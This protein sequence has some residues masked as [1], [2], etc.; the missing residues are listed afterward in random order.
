MSVSVSQRRRHEF[1]LSYPRGKFTIEI[2]R[3][4]R[5]GRDLFSRPKVSY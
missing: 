2:A 1:G 3:H 4:A 5:P